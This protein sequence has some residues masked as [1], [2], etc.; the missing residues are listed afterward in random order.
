M[1]LIILTDGA[2][3]EFTAQ[4]IE[5][6]IILWGDTQR[7]TR[8]VQQINHRALLFAETLEDAT[9]PNLSG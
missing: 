3:M 8:K 5:R 4:T 9:D 2:T 6:Q 7:L 1:G